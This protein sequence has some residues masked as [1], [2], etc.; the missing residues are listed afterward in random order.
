MDQIRILQPAPGLGFWSADEQWLLQFQDGPVRLDL[1]G[2]GLIDGARNNEYPNHIISIRETPVFWDHII[3][4]Y[5]RSLQSL[6]SDHK[7]YNLYEQ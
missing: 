3:N 6:I 1:V 7:Q 2:I 5:I 4:R